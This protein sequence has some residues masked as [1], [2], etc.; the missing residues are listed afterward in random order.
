MLTKLTMNTLKC[1]VLTLVTLCL[2]TCKKAVE[3][4]PGNGGDMEIPAQVEGNGVTFINEGRSAIVIF[5]APEKES[6]HL[7]GSFNDFTADG[8][9]LMTKTADGERWWKQLDDLDPGAVY[10]YQFLINGEEKVADPYT[11]LVLDPINDPYIPVAIYSVAIA[12][13]NDKTS[14]LLSVMQYREEAYQWKTAD[15]NRPH[16]YDLAIYEL[17][18]RD[19]VATHHYQTLRD[20]LSYL[21]NLGV[22]AI[23][24]MPINEFEGNSSWGYNPSFYFAVDKYYGTKNDLKAFIDDCHTR[25]LAVIIDVVLN[26]SFSQSPMVQLYFQDGKPTVGNPWFN[27]EATHPY[28]VGYDMNHESP[29]TKAFVKDVLKHWIQEYRIDGFRFDLSKGF[30]Q[31]NS[32][33]SETHVAAWSAYDASRVAIWKEYNNYLRT[34]DGDLYVILEHFADDQEEQELARD[35]MLFWN[36]LND[37]FNEA[38]MGWTDIGQSDISRIIPQTHDFDSPNLISYMESH[39][40]ERLMFKNLAYGNSHENYDIKE[41]RT[42]L[43]R[44]EMAAAFLFMVPGPKMLWQFGELGYDVSIDENGRTG[45]KP[46]KWHYNQGDRRT[47]YQAF[48][49]FIHFKRNNAV[50]RDGEVEYDLRD[51]LKYIRVKKGEQEVFVIGNFDVKPHQVDVAGLSAGAWFDNL[52]KQIMQ[53]EE[54]FHQS[55]APG[56]YYILSKNQLK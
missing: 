48:S 47:L 15:F 11:A 45:E 28:N 56:A 39:D 31:K 43:K 46:I 18:V 37:G 38:T 22:N 36:N 5:W 55:L 52:S 17:L 51:A 26:H 44:M 20:T 54:G 29:H 27:V 9:S 19:F 1:I 33:T 6:V 24:L 30:T 41:L 4:N 42:A 53:L 3:P 35:G 12:Y 2:V 16:P 34:L 10:S 32:G 49:S 23:E 13:P 8:N 25:G 40:E 14:G 50:F 21:T 7:L